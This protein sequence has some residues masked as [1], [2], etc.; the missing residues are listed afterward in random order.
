MP[1]YKLTIVL[2]FVL[3][4][5]FGSIALSLMSRPTLAGEAPPPPDAKPVDIIALKA[6]VER[7]KGLAT[8]QSH[9]MADVAYHYSNLWFAGQK[10]N[11]PLAQF[12]VDE[13]RAHLRWAVRVIPVR[14]DPKGVE[15]KLADVLSPIEAGNLES[16]R[17]CIA[18]K[19]KAQFEIAY[20]QM[21]GSCYACHLIVGK[22]Y[23]RLQ[24][25]EH[26]ESPMI[27]MS[28]VKEQ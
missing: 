13:V 22:P 8:D 12:Y 4:V 11:W 17:K 16:L 6:D 26:P 25:P 15:I 28:P 7:L 14:K 19:D 5:L 18:D 24:V 3:G 21:M 2:A 23:L 1:R 10:E 9:V 27:N 20:R